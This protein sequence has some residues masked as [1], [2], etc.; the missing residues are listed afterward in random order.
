[1]RLTSRMSSI[2][3]VWRPGVALDGLQRAGQA[4]SP[5]PA[6]AEHVGPAEDGRQ[7]R[8]QLVAERGEELVLGAVG[9]LR[10]V[11]E[12]G[13]VHRQRRAPGQLLHQTE[14]EP[15]EAAPAAD[16]EEAHDPQCLA[17]SGQRR[18]DQRG[19]AQR[20]N[21]RSRSASSA[22]SSFTAAGAAPGAPSAAS[23]GPP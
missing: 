14:V 3:R 23:G 15:L 18:A 1:M 9:L 22:I 2:S 10:A 13:V 7:R 8:A 5:E 17:A 6:R 4:F 19:R 12:L 20:S 11:V 16:G 21:S